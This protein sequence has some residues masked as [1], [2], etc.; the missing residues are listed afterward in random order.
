[1]SNVHVLFFGFPHEH[2]DE[3]KM[4]TELVEGV[5]SIFGGVLV[6]DSNL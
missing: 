2:F 5:S 4:D 6:Q 1:M 3:E